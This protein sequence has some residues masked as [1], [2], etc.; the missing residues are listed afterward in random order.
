MY[1]CA[2]STKEIIHAK[3]KEVAVGVFRFSADQTLCSPQTKIM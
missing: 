2:I 1:K 3:K